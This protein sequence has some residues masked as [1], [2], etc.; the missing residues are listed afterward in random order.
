MD[1]SDDRE[2]RVIRAIERA[3]QVTAHH[4]DLQ[5]WSPLSDTRERLLRESR[6]SIECLARACE[7]YAERAAFAEL[8]EPEITTYARLWSRVEAAASGLRG[9]RLADTRA[10]VG[11]CGSGSVDWVVADLACLYLAAVSVPI[12]TSASPAELRSL[13]EERAFRCIVCSLARLEVLASVLPGCPSVASVVVIDVDAKDRSAVD[14]WELARQTIEE[15]HGVRISVLRLSEVEQLGRRAGL[16][17]YVEPAQRHLTEPD[18]LMT[19]M[20]APESA[21]SPGLALFPE[22]RWV[23]LW[24]AASLDG[25]PRIP[26]VSVD[27]LPL[28]EMTERAAVVRSIREGGLTRF[29]GGRDLST[30]FDDIQRTRPTTLTLSRRVSSMITRRFQSEVAKRS[31]ARGVEVHDEARAARIEREVVVEMR[32][33]LLG[34]RLIYMTAATGEISPNARDF[35]ERCLEIPVF[36]LDLAD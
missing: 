20:Y 14:T 13:I 1:A 6:S 17:P 29:A 19:L 25:A 16:V 28:D 32:G 2:N 11:I 26:R 7:L 30:L 8:A 5:R 33:S 15:E 3:R 35:L 34:D 22:S 10:L 27:Y 36:E 31:E 24:C 12:P 9:E 4:P 21:G 23:E 18:P